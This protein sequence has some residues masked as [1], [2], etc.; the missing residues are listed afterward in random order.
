MTAVLGA[1]V[2][3]RVAIVRLV[4]LVPSAVKS[5]AAASVGAP[6]LVYLGV[7]WVIGWSYACAMVLAGDSA[8]T[9]NACSEIRPHEAQSINRARIGLLL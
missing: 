2:L 6:F 5:F 1:I 7:S 9:G 8:A 3:L 4:P